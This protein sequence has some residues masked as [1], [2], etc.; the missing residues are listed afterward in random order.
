MNFSTTVYKRL[1]IVLHSDKEYENPFLDVDIDAVF[2]HEDGTVITLPGFWN[3]DNEWK[4]RFSAEKAG[5]W[6]YKITCT[7]KDN[8][9]LTD[10]GEI[11]AAPC[12]NP[13]TELEKH[14]YVRLE[15]G[16][17]HFVYGD[18]TPFFYLGDTHWQMPDH[19]HLHDCNYPGCSCGSQF[20][21]LV[22]NR[23]QKGFNVYQTYFAGHRMQDSRVGNPPWW[24][25]CYSLIN[26][27]VFNDT[28]D[29]M[30]EY[31]AD[32]GITVALGF[33]LHNGSI[34]CYGSKEEPVLKFARYCVAR[35]ACY[36]LMWIT[37][38]EITDYKFGS[39]DIWRKAAALV[40][41]LDGYHRPNSAH[42]YPMTLD[43]PRAQT[44][45]NDPWHQW[46]TLQGAHGGYNKLQKRFF[47]ES[48]YNAEKIKPYIEGESQYEDVYCDGFC[49]SDA[50]RMAAWQAM[51]SGCAGYTYGASAIWLFSWE[52]SKKFTYSPDA[53]YEAMDKPVS[54]HMTYMKK[55]Y[56]YVGW[57]KIK[58]S[59]DYE[60]GM[61]EMRKYV[62][63]S[64]IDKD[65]FVFYI[66]SKEK[67]RGYIKGLKE[68]VRYQAR[69]FDP[70]M[71]KFIDLP[72]IITPD[73][74][75]DL[76][77]RP[78]LR[79]WVLLLN[80][81]DLGEYET[82]VYPETKKAVP[83]SEVTPGEKIQVASVSA[84][85]AAEEDHPFE[86]LIDGNP[87]TYWEG[88]HPKGSHE[89]ILDLGASQ[90]VGYVKFVSPQDKMIY[91]DFRIFG[92]NDGKTYDL[93]AERPN[94]TVAVGGPYP[95][96]YEAVSGNY[97]YIKVF[98]NSSDIPGA[99]PALNLSALEVYKK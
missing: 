95:E 83:A 18:G 78:S 49:G 86:N 74:K 60:F 43:D 41:E 31:L 22:E 93:L 73:G 96:Y 42:M 81:Y 94:K 10:S 64:H 63:I 47:Y 80:T 38:Q 8:T 21:H 4:V 5:K 9:S 44:L 55:F 20:K 11:E 69:W 28:M 54:F 90:D 62:S 17:R 14:G 91:F 48:Y 79:D 32:K 66:F 89:I 68:N 87:D 24:A 75:V 39:F 2:T 12:L 13:K 84:L 33:G 7:D 46:W 82:Y 1:E 99:E 35:Y 23:L 71:N 97:R 70:I 85:S 37:A 72:D 98:I 6:T 65:V 59:F 45:D 67:E 56:E 27:K 61:F 26:P 88:Y 16:K 50:A 30:I 57:P 51:Q 36:P 25:K 29:V 77:D 34:H 52:H 92:S 53:W 58:P 40:G 15:P 76:P 3:G 19:E